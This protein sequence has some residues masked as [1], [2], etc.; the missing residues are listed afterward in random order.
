MSS[1]AA[2][3]CRI[4]CCSPRLRGPSRGRRLWEHRA[5]T[6]RGLDEG[7]LARIGRS[8]VG[9]LAAGEGL[10]LLDAALSR[11]ESVLVPARLDVAGLKA[12]ARRGEIVPTLWPG[13]SE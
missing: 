8:G 9:E 10:A 11:D 6:G 4:S 12:Q 3:T 7:R 5:G 13:G 2:G 1:P